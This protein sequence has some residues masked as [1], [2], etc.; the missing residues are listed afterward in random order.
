[1]QGDPISFPLPCNVLMRCAKH[2]I[3]KRVTACDCFM[4]LLTECFCF[5]Y[6]T[7]SILYIRIRNSLIVRTN[8]TVA[9]VDDRFQLDDC[10][11]QCFVL[12]TFD[13]QKRVCCSPK[14]DE[15]RYTNDKRQFC[16]GPGYIVGELFPHDAASRI[17]LHPPLRNIHIHAPGE[18]MLH[19]SNHV[20]CFTI[21]VDTKTV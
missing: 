10:L 7:I 3:V 1:M 15:P 18:L 16:S 2:I 13:K 14:K 19:V 20:R 9:P 8:Q 17:S 11:H 6:G 4:Q 21:I 12:A 5:L